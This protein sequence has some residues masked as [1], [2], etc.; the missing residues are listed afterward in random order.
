MGM[1]IV[2]FGKTA[3]FSE[4]EEVSLIDCRL[5]ASLK[6]S[7]DCLSYSLSLAWATAASDSTC[8]HHSSLRQYAVPGR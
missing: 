2:I 7:D 6:D 1:A 8:R 4:K 5:S 3:R